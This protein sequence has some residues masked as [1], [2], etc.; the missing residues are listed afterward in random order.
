MS[1]LSREECLK[2]AMI[3]GI[4]ILLVYGD[5]TFLGHSLSP[6]LYSEGVLVGTQY[7]Y[8]GRK[9]Y[10]SPVLD[11]LGTG[12][13]IEPALQ[14]IVLRLYSGHFPL[15]DPY[16]GTGAPLAAD[17]TLSTYFP[18]N[19]FY[20]IP[21][22]YWDYVEL[23]K[24]WVAA[25]F[26]FLLLKRFGLSKAA[27]LGGAFAYSLSGALIVNPFVPPTEIAIMIPAVLLVVKGCIDA[28]SRKSIAI[29][30]AVF[31]VT[32]L[33]AHIETLTIQFLFAGWFAIFELITRKTKR[34]KDLF[35]LLSGVALAFGIAAFFLF[36][37]FEYLLSSSLAHG[38]GVGLQSLSS[39]LYVTKLQPVFYWI[40]LFVPYF[41][42][43]F[44][45]YPYA[46]LRQF[47]FWDVFPGYVGTT[48]F[49]L[50]LLP[51][52]SRRLR[53][54][55]LKYY[56]FFLLS[57]ILILTKDFGIPPINWIGYLPVMTFVN[58]RYSSSIL[59]LSFA[60]A[61]AFGL[62]STRR[63]TK[64]RAL[65]AVFAV[66]IAI[67]PALWMSNPTLL[68]P[69]S[70][71]FPVS[72]GYLIFSLGALTLSGCVAAK[73][74]DKA[75]KILAI[76]IVL[77]L[78]AYIP[79]SLSAEYDA[80]RVAILS[81]AG[82]IIAAIGL[83]PGVNTARMVSFWSL[84]FPR[85]KQL[86]AAV[87]IAAM[88]FQFIIASASPLGLPN[89]Y[90]AFTAAPY[91]TFLQANTGL[92]RVFS[93]D[94]VFFPPV[95]GIFSLQNLG[96]FSAF[97]PSS[98]EAF[99][100]M[101]LD[102]GIVSTTFVGN[103]Y[104][105]N[106]DVGDLGSVI[107]SNLAF[108]SLLGVKYFV[109]TTTDP[110]IVYETVVQAE[111]EANSMWIPIGNNSV[112]TEFVT[113]KSFD[114]IAVLIGTYGRINQGDILLALDSVSSNVTIHRVARLR[115]QSLLNDAWGNEFTFL[116]VELANKTEFRVSISQSDTA[117]GN[118]L[119]VMSY[120]QAEPERDLSIE[121]G[122]PNLALGLIQR[123]E[124]LPVAYQD[125]NATIYHN[126]RVFPRA[127]L[128]DRVTSAS[129][130]QEALIETRRLGWDTRDSLVL[131]GTPP[132]LSLLKSASNASGDAEIEQ[133][134]PEE[135]TVQVR[136]SNP[137]FLVL[138][139][140]FYPGWNAYVDGELVTTYRA[141]G[142]VRAVF[143]SAGDHRVSFKY[144]PYSFKIGVYIS[145]LSAATVL[146]LLV[147][148]AWLPRKTRFQRFNR[149]E[150]QSHPRSLSS[151]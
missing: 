134:T 79:R 54:S 56:W 49:F 46:G 109:T 30:T 132:E 8:S 77:E 142:L 119:A 29:A 116:R 44:Q 85:R 38:T 108:Y 16:Q 51:I 114:G 105:R 126:L 81:V 68:L 22:A 78:T 130:L 129:S 113:D 146:L 40:I 110:G 149:M 74:G 27:S 147:P 45:T 67:I 133:Y 127:F 36:P 19:L 41:Y 24:L 66:A 123:D 102:P 33:G 141:Y 7:G 140:T 52:F 23:L 26:S 13:Q 82:L 84:R 32:L 93:V 112:S 1:D 63:L 9:I 106:S 117:P 107:H 21:N 42:G 99:V 96:E 88:I 122:S 98:F 34:I 103:G 18:T 95:A 10:S 2:I 47:F 91:V 55:K 125:Q 35:T 144:E 92:Q 28:P 71:Y 148:G 121:N 145:I 12:G 83:W 59:A 53:D 87:F 60:G 94:G 97:M 90:D 101:N 76:F 70:N 65:G 5:I 89:R 138:T 150:H 86:F 75:P 151:S 124:T 17:P 14:L 118:E 136:A 43:F 115:A 62:D 72:L 135:V 4:T 39:T 120:T 139:D 61:C 31:S 6:A 104:Y 50:S 20:I 57:E 73:G 111:S 3:L 15:W 131:E 137:S 58:W 37:V 128:V 11:P 100:R 80:G 48:V 69:S 64:R 25:L 143:V